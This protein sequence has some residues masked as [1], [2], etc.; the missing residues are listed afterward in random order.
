MHVLLVLLWALRTRLD[1]VLCPGLAA[2][3]LTNLNNLLLVVIQWREG[4]VAT[5]AGALHQVLQSS[6]YTPHHHRCPPCHHHRR[7]LGNHQ[8]P[9]R[10]AVWQAEMQLRIQGPLWRW[11]CIHVH[12]YAPTLQLGR[13]AVKSGVGKAVGM[14][15]RLPVDG[16]KRCPLHPLQLCLDCESQVTQLLAACGEDTTHLLDDQGDVTLDPQ[17]RDTLW[18]HVHTTGPLG[19]NNAAPAPPGPGF[20]RQAPSKRSSHAPSMSGSSV[21]FSSSPSPALVSSSSVSSGR[22]RRSAIL[23]TTT[24]RGS[25]GPQRG[26][27][28]HRGETQRE[29]RPAAVGEVGSIL[30]CQAWCSTAEGTQRAPEGLGGAARVR[31]G[32]SVAEAGTCASVLAA[33]SLDTK[34]VPHAQPAEKRSRKVMRQCCE[35]WCR[36]SEA[37][38]EAVYSQSVHVKR[39]ALC[40]YTARAEAGSALAV[41]G[42]SA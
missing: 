33:D 10:H 20:L 7:G 5:G 19:L 17:A 16:M 38:L 26:A 9:P 42:Q 8:C 2:R 36:L 29:K 18:E 23:D 12:R 31:R 39:C 24:L 22:R 34:G 11:M 28:C 21:T 25:G 15:I 6:L 4:A 27:V 14:T 32:R 37:N 13:E 41:D 1:E 35:S 40:A 30:T 3:R